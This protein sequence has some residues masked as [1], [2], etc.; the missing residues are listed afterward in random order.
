MSNEQE[1]ASFI[2]LGSSMTSMERRNLNID[3]FEEPEISTSNIL[4]QSDNSNVSH[5]KQSA[6][7]GYSSINASKSKSKTVVD[8]VEID[9][10]HETMSLDMTKYHIPKMEVNVAQLGRSIKTTDETSDHALNKTAALEMELETQ[11]VKYKAEVLAL[12]QDL[13]EK[14]SIVKNQAFLIKQLEQQKH[15]SQAEHDRRINILKIR[16]N[17]VEAK[18]LEFQNKIQ[19]LEDALMATKQE[20]AK[21]QL[22]TDEEGWSQLPESAD[23]YSLQLNYDHSVLLCPLCEHSYKDMTTLQNHVEDCTLVV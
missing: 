14:N 2:I 3:E 15:S 7:G 16:M 21:V 22:T 13:S 9:E 18:N 20:L 17:Q 23:I 4:K 8:S 12:S 10:I 6:D 1:D 19:S 11:S 5:I